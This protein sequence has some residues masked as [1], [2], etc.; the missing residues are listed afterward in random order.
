MEKKLNNLVKMVR[1][2]SRFD[3]PCKKIGNY[4]YSKHALDRQRERYIKDDELNAVLESPFRWERQSYSNRT[5]YYEE[6]TGLF[7]VMDNYTNIIITVMEAEWRK[8]HKRWRNS[9]F[10][11]IKPIRCA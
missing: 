7:V 2:R 4:W 8:K 11:V 9:S 5:T 10:K 6:I 1:R 3:Q